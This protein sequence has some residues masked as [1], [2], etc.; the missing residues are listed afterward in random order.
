MAIVAI[1]FLRV[2]T[3]PV[4]ARRHPPGVDPPV[5]GRRPGLPWPP[6]STVCDLLYGLTPQ[7]RRGRDAH[8]VE[9]DITDGIRGPPGAVHGGIVACLVDPAGADAAV[10]SSGRPV[11]TSGVA[12]SYTASARV[13]PLRAVAVVLRVGAQQ[14][15][16]EVRCYA[17]RSR[18]GWGPP[19]PATMS[20]LPGESTVR[21]WPDQPRA[22]PPL[23]E[24]FGQAGGAQA[25]HPPTMASRSARLVTGSSWMRSAG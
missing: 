17:V 12:L 7:L 23:Q 19:R 13:G 4:Q 16:V 11:V 6:M 8:V 14:G 10:R 1:R 22:A 9:L 20:F 24:L 3:R 5:E 2:G 15:V 21:P 18:S 25:S